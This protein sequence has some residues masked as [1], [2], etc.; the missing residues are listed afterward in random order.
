M[1][2][3]IHYATTADGARIAL[4]T[5]GGPNC[6]LLGLQKVAKRQGQG[7][8]LMNFRFPPEQEAFRQELRG[9][10]GENVPPDWEGVF[11]EEEEEDSPACSW[12]TTRR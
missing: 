9:W 1:E 6:R 12:C 2:P 8:G 7:A 5:L 11:L 10:P 4:W 3:P